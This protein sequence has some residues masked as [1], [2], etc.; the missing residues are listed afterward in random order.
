[1]AIGQP[2]TSTP[3]PASKADQLAALRVRLKQVFKPSSELEVIKGLKVA[4]WGRYKVGK[5]HFAGTA[6]GPIYII[7]T[8]GSWHILKLSLP[9]DKRD[10]VHISEVLYKAGEDTNKID[11][12]K[13]MDAMFEALDLLTQ[14]ILLTP[15]EEAGTIVIDSMTDLWDWLAI[16]KDVA[17]LPGPEG[18]L[19]WGHA[20]K[21]YAEFMNM[22]LVSKWHVVATFKAD[23][24]VDK[25]GGSVMMGDDVM[26]KPKWQKKTG[27]AFDVIA[28]MR[29]DADGKRRLVLE[30]DRFGD[31][32]DTLVDPSWPKLIALFSKRTGVK[33]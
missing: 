18:R 6:P 4:V 21:R 15:E 19:Q 9:A 32:R 5:S 31:I 12:L 7:D 3:S 2:S 16:W 10:N 23:E 22:L 30:G 20:N 24:M 33:L 28:Q 25:K 11:I 13:A 8:E 27:H 17:D 29:K 26:Y 14:V 1:M